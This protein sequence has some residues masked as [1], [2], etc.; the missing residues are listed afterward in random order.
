MTLK[1]P[2]SL[3]VRNLGFTMNGVFGDDATQ[4]GVY[5][6][7]ASELVDR[8]LAGCNST[9]LA[10]G[11]TGS[12]KTYTM[13][14]GEKAKAKL[15]KELGEEHGIIPR[16]C[17]QLFAGIK[18]GQ[19]IKASLLFDG[20]CCCYFLGGERVGSDQARRSITLG[21]VC[22][23]V[24]SLEGGEGTR[25]R[26]RDAGGL[27]SG[28]ATCCMGGRVQPLKAPGR[29]GRVDSVRPSRSPA[30][31]YGKKASPPTPPSGIFRSRTSKSTTTRSTTCCAPTTARRGGR[32]SP[33]AR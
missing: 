17:K 10:Y 15:D 24:V 7:S 9:M 1:P 28:A 13:L 12:G 3:T 29:T 26:L 23:Y 21:R 4:K 31:T 18:P 2:G 32:I 33:S 16:A 11:Q 30:P 5:D 19:S 25:A 20:S 22:A 14:G 8:V 27:A 6:A